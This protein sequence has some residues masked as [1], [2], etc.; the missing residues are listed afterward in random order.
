MPSQTLQTTLS[1]AERAAICTHPLS[2]HLFSLMEQKQSNLALAA[3][4]TSSKDLLDL[5]Q[6]LGPYLCVLKTHIDILDDFTP[7]VCKQL[8]QI[9]NEH[10]FL[11]FEDRKFADIGH[12]VLQQ[13]QGGVYKIHE[14]AHLVN[15]HPLPG[16]GIIDGLKKVGQSTGRG[17][18]LLA[19]LS[20]QGSL[21]DE[22]YVR[23]TVAMAESH[24]DFVVGFICQQR[25]T[26]DPRFIHMTPGVQ[27]ADKSDTLGQQYN[28]PHHVILEKGSDIA[29]VGRGII[30]HVDPMK[31]AEDY[32]EASWVAYQQRVR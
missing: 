25:L 19:Q 31:A 4:V 32:R 7:S 24:A 16:P 26:Q 17:L 6:T 10:N 14:W 2:R 1:F 30:K 12:T 5:A 27:F 11:I 13:Y 22:N 23:G 20:S 18:L 9:A 29:I 21:I 8:Q 3:D 15:A 28:T